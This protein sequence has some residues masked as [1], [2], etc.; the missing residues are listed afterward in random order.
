MFGLHLIP[1]VFHWE[2]SVP[3]VAPVQW[4]EVFISPPLPQEG[5]QCAVEGPFG[6]AL[7]CSSSALC[8]GTT[9]AVGLA[10]PA[11]ICCVLVRAL[12]EG[13][14][15]GALWGAFA[16]MLLQQQ[17]WVPHPLVVAA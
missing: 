13:P 6:K 11:A 2:H 7:S 12:L 8:T 16:W 9:Q 15:T 17:L 5:A 4:R 1:A 3:G 14:A 10:H